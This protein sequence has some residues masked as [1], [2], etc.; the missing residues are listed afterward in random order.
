[1]MSLR[2]NNGFQQ[3]QA[4]LIKD[5]KHI[6]PHLA[7]HLVNVVIEWLRENWDSLQDWIV[8]NWDMLVD[9]ARAV[10]GM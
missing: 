7:Q 6:I 9:A 3:V 1:M 2:R 4:M 10:V 8:N 5:L